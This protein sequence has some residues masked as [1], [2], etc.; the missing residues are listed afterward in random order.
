MEKCFF[1]DDGE[2]FGDWAV[3]ISKETLAALKDAYRRWD[4]SGGEDLSLLVNLM[5][6]DVQFAT[7]PDGTKPLEFS[8]PCRNKSEVLCYLEGLLGDWDLLWIEIEE[9]VSE[10]N[11]VV[12]LLKNG[13]RNRRTD[14][15]IESHAAHAWRFKGQ[16]ASHIRLFFDSGK[17]SAAAAET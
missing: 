7:L 8:K 5:D 10:R 16:Q 17:W 1:D 11:H 14:K 13:W 2:F 3:T 4:E 6:E 12:V 9:I 15:R